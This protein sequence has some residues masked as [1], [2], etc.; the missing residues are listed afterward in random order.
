M[1]DATNQTASRRIVVVGGSGNLGAALMR[2]L[3]SEPG[4][5]RVGISRREP[6]SA[7]PFDGAEWRSIDVS[8]PSATA[9]LAET[10]HGADAV[11]HL[12]WKLQPSH[13]VPLM[14]ATNVAGTARVLDA[15]AL[16][17]VPQVV[18][19]SSVGAYSPGPKHRRVDEGWPTGGLPTSHYATHK[20]M[21]ERAMDAF[22]AAHPEV[23]LTR[24][25]PGLVFQADA[26]QEVARLFLGPLVPHRLI[27]RLRTPILP[28]P[29]TV[30]SQVVHADDVADGIW[31][32]IDRTAGGAFNLAAEPVMTPDVLASLLGGRTVPIRRS[33]VRALIWLT[34][35][36]R[37]QPTDPGWLD[38]AT[39]V[40]VMS[41][42]RARSVLGWEPTVSAQDALRE[43][44]DAM[45]H[46]TGHPASA[47][48]AP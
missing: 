30:V 43:F 42:E 47:S 40:P 6:S 5:S 41:T 36:A 7:P 9:D 17:G 13:D 1:A 45:A 18:V 32:S 46:G 22:E 14:R 4:V 11:V 2:R 34:W 28:L 10:F 19:A 20:A 27:G 39:S 21:N 3:A 24:I 44:L 25:R 29:S 48:L 8:T 23:V 33:V 38:I 37:L 12:A 31:R 15:A 26:A 35:K 16:A